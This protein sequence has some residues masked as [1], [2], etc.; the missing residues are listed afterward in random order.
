MP[1]WGW[2]EGKKELMKG[3]E[4]LFESGYEELSAPV[5]SLDLSGLKPVSVVLVSQF[6]Q[7][8]LAMEAF[9]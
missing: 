4:A 3:K 7:Q 5:Q 8:Y 1:V 9:E 6:S 2:W